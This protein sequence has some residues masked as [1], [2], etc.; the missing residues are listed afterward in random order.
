[1]AALGVII[2]STD[3]VLLRLASVS[4]LDAACWRNALIA[5]TLTTY[6]LASNRRS[7]FR[8]LWHMGWVGIGVSLVYGINNS[9]FVFALSHTTIAN[10]IVILAATPLFAACFS[11][12]WLRERISRSTVAA[13]AFAIAGVLIVFA[14]ALSSGGWLG[15]LFALALAVSTGGLFT[16]LRRFPHL[17]RIPAI[18]L[19]AAAAATALAP[20]AN[21]LTISPQ[22]LGLLMVVG[23]MIKPL[24]SI[25]ILSAPRYI[26]AAEVGLLMLLEVVLAPLWGWL[27]AAEPIA[28]ATVYGGLVISTSVLLHIAQQINKPSHSGTSPDAKPT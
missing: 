10:T 1:M 8:E 15:N 24:S 19:G 12:W 14:G 16:A 21:L 4:A 7:E 23:C 9:L 27:F 2:L 22:A 3:A 25:L 5:L 26:T 13:I 28:M 20:L 6:L 18:A 17:H 11:R